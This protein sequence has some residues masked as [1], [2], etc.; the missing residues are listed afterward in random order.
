[1]ADRTDLRDLSG[2]GRMRNAAANKITVMCVDDHR[3][4]REGLTLIINRVADMQVVA[5][6]ANG[7]EAVALFR[8]HAPNIVLMD[9]EMPKLNG[10]EAIRQIRQ[11]DAGARVVVLTVFQGDEDIH[12]AL[13]VGAVTYLLKDT[14]SDDLVRTIRDVHA[15]KAPTTPY[16][17]ERLASRSQQKALSSREVQVLTL[18]AE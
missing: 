3:L 9:L 18:V 10:I 15:G 11:I 12:R 5:A 16:I 6:A 4:V 1:M 17:E 7:E 2:A 13:Q 14:L 8:Q